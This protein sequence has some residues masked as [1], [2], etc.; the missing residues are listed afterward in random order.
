[1]IIALIALATIA[2]LC[3]AVGGYLFF[4]ACGKHKE[5]HW[6]D[7]AEISRTPY[8]PYYP[9]VRSSYEWLA[10]HRAQ[11]IYISSFDGTRL[12][13][14]W[15]PCENARGT[16]LLVHGYHSCIYTDFG[17]AVEPYHNMGMNILLPDQRC[18]GKSGGRFTTFGVKESK[19]MLCWIHH[20][21]AQLGEFPIMLSGLSMGAATVM[22]MADEDLPENVRYCIADCGFTSPKEIISQVFRDVIHLPAWPVMWAADLFARLFAGFRLDEK[23]SLRSLRENRLPFMFVHGLADDFVPCDMTRRSFETCAGEKHLLLVEG[24][25]HGVSYIHAKE[26]Y[27]EMNMSIIDRIFPKRKEEL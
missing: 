20:H 16:V 27:N 1:M 12:H 6:L 19:D 9:H 18:H 2:S 26:K 15:V 17:L 14:T 22:F 3:F 25:G 7:E 11:D 23:N 8:A 10:K 21:N 5:I 4:T 13:A 24:A